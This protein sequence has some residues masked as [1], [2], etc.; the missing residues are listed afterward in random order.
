MYSTQDKQQ[1]QKQEVLEGFLKLKVQSQPNDSAFCPVKLET[2]LKSANRLTHTCLTSPFRDKPSSLQG[3]FP[4][5]TLC[6]HYHT[7]YLEHVSLKSGTQ[8]DKCL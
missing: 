3:L 7:D 2:A 5:V 8:L 1:T 4:D 6:A